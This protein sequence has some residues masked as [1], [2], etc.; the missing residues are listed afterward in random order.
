MVLLIGPFALF[1]DATNNA[2]SAAPQDYCQYGDR[3]TL[4][5][6]DR[7][8]QYDDLD[9][10]L[11]V[12]GFERIVSTFRAGDRVS[13]NTIAG[14][15]SQ[16]ERVFDRC[17]PGCPDSGVLS[18][19]FS[20]CRSMVARADFSRFRV[21]LASSI[22]RMLDELRSYERSDIIRTVARVTQT[23]SGA[24]VDTED[25]R[26]VRTVF[27]FSDLLENSSDLPWPKIIRTPPRDLMERLR[28]D[29]L[30]PRLD[31]ARVSAFGIGR[32]HDRARSPLGAANEKRLRDFWAALLWEG[33]AEH[34]YVGRRLD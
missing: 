16:S 34:V 30:L 26:R 6:I 10:E 1:G 12:R 9:K 17:V 11:F 32:N 18:W 3:T 23:A 8:T 14:D 5:F 15:Y 4:I 21:E 20:T 27:I 29:D 22:R 24:Q 2:T 33:A 31:G 19:V 7:T 13:V 28:R 25:A